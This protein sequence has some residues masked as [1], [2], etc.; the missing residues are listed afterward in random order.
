[1]RWHALFM[2]STG[3]LARWPKFTKDT[4]LVPCDDRD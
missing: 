4:T 3:D 1:M 2:L